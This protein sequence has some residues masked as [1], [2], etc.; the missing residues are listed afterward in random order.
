GS[1]EIGIHGCDAHCDAEDFESP[2]ISHELQSFT[3]CRIVGIVPVEPHAARSVEE[4]RGAPFIGESGAADL[5]LSVA[6]HRSV[7]GGH[8][9]VA[10]GRATSAAASPS[11]A[12]AA[13][14]TAAA[15]WQAAT[16]IWQTAAAAGQT[17]AATERAP[18]ARGRAATS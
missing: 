4:D 13:G 7:P 17:T 18:H 11:R 2:L 3:A 9:A 16:A 6:F 14:Q 10:T 5:K 1:V 12:A 15:T 8:T